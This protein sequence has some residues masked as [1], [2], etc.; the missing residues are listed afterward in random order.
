MHTIFVVEDDPALNNGIVL[1]LKQENYSF[2]QC[3]T[4]SSARSEWKG[5]GS[6]L[7]SLIILDI[8]MGDGSGLD[9]CRAIR[10]VSPVPL[11]LLTARDTEMDMVIGL[12]AG[13][14]DYL[15]K[16]FSLAVLRARVAALLR[17]GSTTTVPVGGI[18]SGNF[19]SDPFVFD[20]AAMQFEKGGKALELSR[21]EQR[22]LRLL[23]A[24]PGQ[25]ITR[26][27][28]L[29]KIWTGEA[30]YVYGNA[31]SVTVRRL[32]EKLEDDPAKPRHIKTVY[33]VGYTW[34]MNDDD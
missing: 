22:L 4:L 13:A 16:P 17:R 32:R 31:L 28:L 20:F 26:E 27:T 7:P 34:A 23:T 9:W 30:A 11:L 5:H 12:E 19:K 14:D 8:N 29:D 25:T 18:E 33:G 1:S 2:V 21:T 6:A 24:N 15:T 10:A 3:L